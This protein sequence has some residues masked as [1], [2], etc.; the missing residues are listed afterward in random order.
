MTQKLRLQMGEYYTIVGLSVQLMA[1]DDTPANADKAKACQDFIGVVNVYG[2]DAKRRYL[3]RLGKDVPADLDTPSADDNGNQ[4]SGDKP[5]GGND[6]PSGNDPHNGATDIPDDVV[7][8][9]M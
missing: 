4:P 8:P 9:G 6:Q 3:Q 1:N 2:A 7:F 5:S